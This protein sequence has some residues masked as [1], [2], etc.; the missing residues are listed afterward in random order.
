MKGG[1]VASVGPGFAG[2]MPAQCLGFSGALV[3]IN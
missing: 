1:G 2:E 3:E